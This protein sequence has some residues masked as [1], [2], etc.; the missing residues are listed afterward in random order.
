MNYFLR[1]SSKPSFPI[2]YDHDNSVNGSYIAMGKYIRE[3]VSLPLK[4]S[5]S[6][7]SDVIYEKL[8]T[9]DV[10]ESVGGGWLVSQKLVDIIKSFFPNEVQFFKSVFNYQ[11]KVCSSYYAINIYNKI[12]C[13]D[14]NE[15]NYTRHPVDGSY[16]FSKIVLKTTPLEEYG[17]IYNIVRD[18][19]SNEVVVS[20]AFVKVI[21]SNKINSIIF[22]K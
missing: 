20:E 5:D 1:I 13:C 21:K 12:D 9:Y 17:M 6:K 11:N 3:D 15:S 18:S 16:D 22:K 7:N 14:M 4:Y 2:V 8:L 10:L 19:Y